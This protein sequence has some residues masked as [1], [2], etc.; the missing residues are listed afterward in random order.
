MIE[1][2]KFIKTDI[3]RNFKYIILI[4]A[5]LIFQGGIMAVIPTINQK[6]ID[7]GV[8][9]NN[10]NIVLKLIA[11]LI[12]LTLI[13]YTISFG[14]TLFEEQFNNQLEKR[15]QKDVF[16]HLLK[17]KSKYAHDFGLFSMYN[18]MQYHISKIQ[19]IFSC[20]LWN[21]II[22]IIKLIGGLIGLFLVN[23]QMT[24]IVL[25]LIPIKLAFISRISHLRKKYFGNFIRIQKEKNRLE[26]NVLE[27]F[28]EIKLWNMY[29]SKIKEYCDLILKRQAYDKQLTILDTFSNFAQMIFDNILVYI[30]YIMAS[31]LISESRISIGSLFAFMAYIDFFANP[32]YF[33]SQLKFRLEEVLPSLHA[34]NEFMKL[35]EE[36]L[37]IDKDSIAYPSD[38]YSVEFRKINVNYGEKLAVRDFSLLVKAGEKIAIIGKNGSGKTTLIRSLLRLEDLT[39]GNI[40]I[41]GTDIGQIPLMEYREKISYMSQQ[42]YLFNSSILDNIEMNKNCIKFDMR[43]NKYFE[44]LLDFTQNRQGGILL[45]VGVNG[46]KLSAGERQR[47]VLARNLLKNSDI[48]VFDEPTANCDIETEQVFYEILNNTPKTVIVVTHDEKIINHVNRVL[49]MA[50]GKIVEERICKR[51]I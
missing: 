22:Q 47:V 13:S 12:V 43:Y 46:D 29:E 25:L 37:R 48:L 51:E 11:F 21:L 35:E 6:L 45:N 2:I 39:S 23:W 3:Q 24:I 50:H 19:A 40:L 49:K 7:S 30:I 9:A 26:E 33:F 41:N 4:C 32:I 10:L 27:G 1:I 42:F 14:E 15:I 20:Q 38:F 17:L 18:N 36:N 8:M 44:K 16:S 5:F 34:L 28:T 31:L